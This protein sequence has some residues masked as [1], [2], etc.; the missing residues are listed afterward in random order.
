V[1][2]ADPANHAAPG[3]GPHARAPGP[4]RERTTYLARGNGCRRTS[5]LRCTVTKLF[6]KFLMNGVDS[7]LSPRAKSGPASE[8]RPRRLWK[9][10]SLRKASAFSPCASSRDRSCARGGDRRGRNARTRVRT[11]DVAYDNAVVGCATSC[12]EWH[13][14]AH[15]RAVTACHA[16]SRTVVDSARMPSRRE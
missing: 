6:H 15:V 5:S 14:A 10:A 4:S 16:D 2:Q 3:T 8:C 1:A 9:C 11:L 13:A 7:L 12:N